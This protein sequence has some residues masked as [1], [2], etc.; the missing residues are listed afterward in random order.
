VDVWVGDDGV[1]RKIEV[2]EGTSPFVFEFFDFGADVDIQPPPAAE[3]QDL[4]GLFGSATCEAGFGAP[5]GM[6]RAMN[7]LRLHGFTIAGEPTCSSESATFENDS[8]VRG[9]E[10]HVFCV[11]RASAPA[12]APSRVQPLGSGTSAMALRLNN[13]ECTL[14]ADT[15]AEAKLARLRAA[16]AALER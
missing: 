14:V 2:T 16:L 3:V 6:A 8:A 1:V 11:V 12:Y 7:A 15:G 4:D 10:G 9:K 5:I 13:L